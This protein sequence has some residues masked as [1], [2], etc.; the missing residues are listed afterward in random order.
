MLLL[1]SLRQSADLKRRLREHMVEEGMI[2]RDEARRSHAMENGIFL[3]GGT[4]AI[5]RA[6]P[7][8]GVIGGG[9]G[10]GGSSSSMSLDVAPVF[11]GAWFDQLML[12]VSGAANNARKGSKY[13]GNAVWS[14]RDD[15]M[16]FMGWKD[17][18]A[19]RAADNSASAQQILTSDVKTAALTS[20]N[21][22]QC[23]ADF[24]WERNLMFTPFD[25]GGTLNTYANGNLPPGLQP[26]ILTFSKDYVQSLRSQ[27]IFK[28]VDHDLY[29]STAAFVDLARCPVVF[30]IPDSSFHSILC[31]IGRRDKNRADDNDFAEWYNNNLAADLNLPYMREVVD[32][33]AATKANLMQLRASFMVSPDSK[34]VDMTLLDKFQNLRDY[35]DMEFMPWVDLILT[36]MQPGDGFDELKNDTK[37]MDGLKNVLIQSMMPPMSVE[38]CI[39]QASAE[40]MAALKGESTGRQAQLLDLYYANLVHGASVKVP[41]GEIWRPNNEMEH[42]ESDTSSFFNVMWTG[43]KKVLERV[44]T[45]PALGQGGGGVAMAEYTDQLLRSV[46]RVKNVKRY[47][48]EIWEQSKSFRVSD[49]VHMTEV[50]IL[51]RLRN[52]GVFRWIDSSDELRVGGVHKPENLHVCFYMRRW[53]V[54]VCVRVWMNA[55]CTIRPKFE[56]RI[57]QVDAL[58]VR[59]CCGCGQEAFLGEDEWQ[60]QDRHN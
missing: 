11:T 20:G 38:T 33:A 9:G 39:Q 27:K 40:R 37:Q 3:G 10:G 60:C 48:K 41:L 19:A 58:P 42:S 52:D 30:C 21:A 44:N 56:M 2:S 32:T 25:F 15:V 12:K 14:V 59:V 45:P 29:I 16:R 4:P 35:F 26:S 50:Q 31:L 18:D 36:H 7:G 34:I 46:N 28:E 13:Y 43:L 55:L 1:H 54:C 5:L 23:I 22:S 17:V 49:R 51:Q 57:R 8:H 6:V 47:M 53:G 24:W